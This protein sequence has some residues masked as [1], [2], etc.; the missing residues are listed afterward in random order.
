MAERAKAKGGETI[1]YDLAEE[2]YQKQISRIVDGVKG[3]FKSLEK[4]EADLEE[5]KDDLE[6]EKLKKMA[7]CEVERELNEDPAKVSELENEIRRIE[8]KMKGLDE[9]LGKIRLIKREA[10]TLHAKTSVG[11]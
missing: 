8:D 3:D 2:E 7:M 6:K 11:M 9:A 5:Q 10:S 4:Y 1:G